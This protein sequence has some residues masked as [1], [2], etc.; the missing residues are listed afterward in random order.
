MTTRKITEIGV[1]FYKAGGHKHDGITSSLIDTSKYSIFDFDLSLSTDNGDTTRE[2]ARQNNRNRFDQ[3]VARFITNQVLAPAGIILPADSVKGINIGANEITANN[4]A[5][6]T[7]TANNIAANTITAAQIAANTITSDL[8]VSNFV[9][10]NTTISSNNF[11]YNPVT[12]LGTGWAIYGNGDAILNNG[13]F[14]GKI[15]VGGFDTSSFH[16]DLGGNVWSGAANFA[17]GT[18]KVYSNGQTSLASGGLIAYSNGA[19]NIAGTTSISGN[20]NVTGNSIQFSPS[21]ASARVYVNGSLSTTG[22]LYSSESITG[23]INLWM[24]N[25][26]NFTAGFLKA[27]SILEKLFISRTTNST[28]PVVG[29]FSDQIVQVWNYYNYLDGISPKGSLAGVGFKC[30]PGNGFTTGGV[31]RHYRGDPGPSEMAVG[32]YNGTD[33]GNILAKNFLLS[34]SAAYKV[35]IEYLPATSRSI[36][37][38]KIKKLKPARWNPKSPRTY[39][40]GS[41]KF[42]DINKRWIEKGRTPLILTD[43]N[44]VEIEHDCEI[45][46]CKLDSNGKCN[47]KN[48]VNL[49]YGFIAEDIGEVFP[50]AAAYDLDNK[51]AAI[52]YAKIVFG[53]VEVAQELIEKVEKL[54][55]KIDQLSG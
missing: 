3:Y 22:T 14:S 37:I 21:N 28:V 19:V 32:L 38:Q 2:T 8:L 11:T 7:I 54:E 25:Q 55:Q 29:V 45:L 52:D 43:K 34:S 4:I 40:V 53:L 12:G 35:N 47:N 51:A 39:I 49:D 18:F 48:R 13:I 50:E 42:R 46:E 20:L 5:A 33:Y 17:S 31:I 44:S 24:G 41:E 30:G 1:T 26:A 16:V 15:D 27:D 9:V 23:D 10:V 6:N 36:S